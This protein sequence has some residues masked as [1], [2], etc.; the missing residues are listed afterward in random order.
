MYVTRV[1]QIRNLYLCQKDEGYYKQHHD[2][3]LIQGNRT[4][5]TQNFKTELKDELT[6]DSSEQAAFDGENRTNKE[7]LTH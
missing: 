2:Y 6:L 5:S 3:N 4:R 1:F 7:N